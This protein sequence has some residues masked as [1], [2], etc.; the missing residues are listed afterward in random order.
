MLCD[1]QNVAEPEVT[2]Q[3][4]AALITPRSTDLKERVN[5]DSL[6]DLEIDDDED[7]VGPPVVTPN[8]REDDGVFFGGFLIKIMIEDYNKCNN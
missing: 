5:Q 6:L 3:A 8:E 2:P 4:T 7:D 1:F